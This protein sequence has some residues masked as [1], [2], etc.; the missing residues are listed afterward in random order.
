MKTKKEISLVK[1]I[2]L[3]IMTI[4]I[5]S[6]C[7][8]W[9]DQTVEKQEKLNYFQSGQELLKALEESKNTRN[10][11]F[12]GRMMAAESQPLMAKTDMVA[13]TAGGEHSTT[14]VQVQG[15]DEA[16]I[17]KTDGK[18]IYLIAQNN[19]IIAK[20]VPAKEAEIVSTLKL[21]NFNPQELFIDE[22]R[23]LVFGQEYYQAVPLGNENNPKTTLPTKIRAPDYYWGTNFVSVKLF[24]LKDKEN[25]ELIKQVGLEGNYLTSRKINQDVY[26]V[27]NAYPQFYK[28]NH[29]CEEILPRYYEGKTEKIT[30]EDLAPI[31][32]CTQIGYVKPLEAENFITVASISMSDEDQ[33]VEKEIILGSGQN[34]YASKNN[35]YVAQTNYPHYGLLGELVQEDL[36]VEKTIIT[37]FSL[38]QGEVNFQGVGEVPGHILNQFSMDEEKKF[39]R[40]ATTK[41][42]AFRTRSGESLSANNVYILDQNLEVVGELEDLAPGETIYSV[43]FMGERG[44]VVTFKKVDPLFVLDLENPSNPSVLGKLKI[45]G[46]SDYLHPYD[47]NHLIGIGK[48]AVEAKEGDFAWYQGVKMALFD[49]SDVNNPREKYKVVIGDRG[50]DSPVLDEHKA[51]LFDK[52]RELLVL[53]VTVAKIKGEQSQDN[54]YGEFVFQGAYVYKL[55]L[56]DGFELRGKVSHLD[57]DSAYLKS[58][59]WM[60][61]E[62]SIQRSLYI[63]DV[64][65]TLS[66]KRLQLNDLKDLSKLKALEFEKNNYPYLEKGVIVS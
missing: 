50:T 39:F 15:V 22:N 9:G 36:F 19:L 33:K 62:A 48:E 54:Q 49:V 34:V 42:Q 35:L 29:L 30:L 11:W 21:D 13:A 17:I 38:K 14:N 52:E 1:I 28:E 61:Y 6:G 3:L 10:R 37:K 24:D 27:I 32:T 57:D 20:A 41:G 55:N 7:T 26:F 12:S 25:P 4:T 43:R 31:T 66:F 58:G 44:Y 16:D 8:F 53:P 51:F 5:F 60:D 56:D 2:V 45:P 64:L 59:Y 23:L 65:Y 47:E 46:Y 40:I 18:Y 63:D